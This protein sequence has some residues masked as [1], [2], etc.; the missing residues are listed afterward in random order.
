VCA[1]YHAF[2]DP[3]TGD[4]L[5][6]RPGNRGNPVIAVD[7]LREPVVV[8]TIDRTVPGMHDPPAGSVVMKS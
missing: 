4:D 1:H 7:A 3:A 2:I 8:R 5:R 6:D